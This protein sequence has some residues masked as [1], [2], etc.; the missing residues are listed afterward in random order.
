MKLL[1]DTHSFLWFIEGSTDLSSTA[2][3]LIENGHNESLISVASLWEIAIKH[4]IGKLSLSMP[5]QA[6]ITSQLS[7]FEQLSIQMNHLSV[8]ATLPLH[9]RD[10]CDRLLITQA[11]VEKLP[12][13]SADGAF[14]AYAIQRLW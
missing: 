10:P 7:D 13:V 11:M 5:F 1:L 3:S 2:R 8:V 14:D 9:H 12:L 6:W 4:S